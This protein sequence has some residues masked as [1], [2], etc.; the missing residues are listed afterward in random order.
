MN[1]QTAQEQSSIVLTGRITLPQEEFERTSFQQRLK[2]NAI[3]GKEINTVRT[4]SMPIRNGLGD[5]LPAGRI[6]T[7]SLVIQEVFSSLVSAS[8][9]RFIF[10]FTLE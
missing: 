5:S 2:G 6:R 10:F 3:Q 8:T 9:S 4:R 1:P 7:L